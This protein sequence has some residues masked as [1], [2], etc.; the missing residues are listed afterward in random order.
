MCSLLSFVCMLINDMN[1]IPGR[2][3]IPELHFS[4]STTLFNN[5]QDKVQPCCALCFSEVKCVNLTKCKQSRDLHLCMVCGRQCVTLVV[6][7]VRLELCVDNWVT[8]STQLYDRATCVSF[9]LSLECALTYTALVDEL[10]DKQCVKL[11]SDVE[12]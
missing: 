3:P 9:M 4:S 11:H 5:M 7:A 10:T 1:F 2:F 8:V 6:V 12:Q